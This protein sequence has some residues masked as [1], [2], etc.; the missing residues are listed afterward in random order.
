[1]VRGGFKEVC[2]LAA[3][4]PTRQ[5]ISFGQEVTRLRHEADLSRLE[6]A[7]RAAVSRSYIAQLENGT[8]RCRRDFAI[9]LDEALGTGTTLTAC[10]F[11]L[12]QLVLPQ[13]GNESV[14]GARL[15]DAGL[16]L[17]LKD[18]SRQDDP[19]AVREAVRELLEDDR[20]ATGAR[21]IA[22]EIGS[23]PAPAALVPE[24]EALCAS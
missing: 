12:P 16:A 8:T 7:K 9:R 15:A 10:A 6:L 4:R 22:D 5:T 13:L 1:M 20:Y 14:W 17:M 3:R 18:P 19:A 23:L 11:G 2:H 24:L 21:K